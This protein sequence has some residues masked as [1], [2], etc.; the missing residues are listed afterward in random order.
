MYEVKVDS[1]LKVLFLQKER[2]SPNR[3]VSFLS[4]QM[5]NKAGR[6]PHLNNRL[7]YL[8]VYHPHPTDDFFVG[9]SPEFPT[10]P[11]FS[12]KSICIILPFIR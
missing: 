6:D 2:V 9:K 12:S 8:R 11:E 3:K 4:Y 7:N 5:V 10:E 1:P